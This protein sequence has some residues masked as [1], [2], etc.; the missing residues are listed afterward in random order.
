MQHAISLLF[1]SELFTF[2]YERMVG[3]MMADA[4]EVIVTGLHS[5]LMDYQNTNPHDLF[6]L[7]HIVLYYGHRHPS[8]F[9]SHRKWRKLL[10]TLGEV[11]GLGGDEVRQL[12]PPGLTIRHSS[13]V[14]HRSRPAFVYLQLTS[15]TR[16][17]ECRNSHLRSLPSLT[18]RLLTIYSRWWKRREIFRTRR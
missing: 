2:H 18:M 10:P 15:C 7:Y 9:R 14:F 1:E 13:R 16:F 17:A 3:I 12:H 6:I 4:Q 5:M 11:V 8:L